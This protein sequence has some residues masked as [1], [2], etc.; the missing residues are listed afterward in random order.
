MAAPHVAG[1]AAMMKSV[2]P[3]LTGCQLRT[4]ITQ[5]GDVIPG[6]TTKVQGGRRLNALKCANAALLSLDMMYVGGDFDGDNKPETAAF[7]KTGSN[8][9]AL[10]MWDHNTGSLNT[11][12]P[13]AAWQSS[14]FD[15]EKIKGRVVT[16]DFDGDGKC[17]IAAFYDS[18]GGKTTL[19]IWYGAMKTLPGSGRQVPGADMIHTTGSWTSTSFDATK[20]TGK[21]V[22]GNFDGAKNGSKNT[23]RIAAFYDGGGSTTKLYLW[24]IS[25]ANRT[26]SLISNVSNGSWSSSTFSPASITGKVT[27]GDFDGDG[28]SNIAAFYDYGGS[29]TGL[30]IW[31]ISTSM[32]PALAN[33]AYGGSWMSTSYTAGNINNRVTAGDYDGDGRCN[34][35]AL[36]TYGGSTTKLFVWNISSSMV[37]ATANSQGSWSPSSFVAGFVDNKIAS[38]DYSQD[39]KCDIRWIYVPSSGYSGRL[40]EHQRLTST[41][42]FSSISFAWYNN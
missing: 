38:V 28:R 37:V 39:G 7:I 2:N 27:A 26:A 31:N 33:G 3:N 4:M 14:T 21:V 9:T 17:D 25:P 5:N 13:I 34:I 24:T 42:T 19:F 20:M 1:I 30:F 12:S 36:Y 23:D 18:G 22:A 10:V 11:T 6:L 35:S 41:S 29:T 15:F 8:S 32:V 40:V 16:G